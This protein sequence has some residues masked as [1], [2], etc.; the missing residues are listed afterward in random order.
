METK[1]ELLSSKSNYFYSPSKQNNITFRT[2]KLFHFHPHLSNSNSMS[3]IR[4][5]ITLKLKTAKSL[6]PR[7]K[8]EEKAIK[9]N[10]NFL[11]QDLMT[12]RSEIH[13]RKNDLHLLKIKFNKLLLDNIYNKTL[14]A[15]ILDI[16]MNK[17]ISK[18]MVFTKIRNCRLN[19]EKKQALLE[20]HE[21]LTLKLDIENKKNLLE[22]K[23]LYINDLEKNSKKKIVNNLENEYFI[24]CEKQRTLLKKLEKLEKKYN[25]YERKINEENEKI[26]K[27]NMS[28][29]K[30]IDIE[31]DKI[32]AVQKIFE[33]K[34]VIIRQMNQLVDKIKKL[35]K[36]NNDKEKQIKDQEKEI[37]LKV[38]KYRIISAYKKILPEEQTKI[39]SKTKSKEEIES[40]LKEYEKESKT[41]LE[42]YDTLNKKMYK[43]RDEKPKL[44]RKAV[45]PRKEIERMES[46]KKELEELKTTKEKT[47]KN[48]T[49]KQKDLKDINVQDIKDN[50]QYT[51]IIEKNNNCKDELNKKID[52]LRSKLIELNTKSNNLF[53]K[54]NKEKSEFDK[55]NQNLEET[56]KQFEQNDLEYKE[57]KEKQDE[58]KN[59]EQNKKERGRKRDIDRLKKDINRYSNENRKIS[60][61]N[62]TLQNELDNFNKGLEDFEQIKKDLSDAVAKLNSLKK[63]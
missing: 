52:E 53:N 26:K 56:K 47:E 9:Y 63:N 54:L 11:K 42:E 34:C 1:K 29:D 41:L 37:G 48:H 22:E 14:L 19:P 59:K 35:E 28:N 30:L 49:Q 2:A 7:L 16:P 32:D 33:E 24:K 36:T 51:E 39:N 10:T 21:V 43:Y 8:K 3:D 15:K 23:V 45:E 38:Q 4:Q 40:I 31:V 25:L 44:L 5:G 55:L 58:E 46:L 62:Q 12:L 50:E 17:I 13:Q 6:F 20:A 60:E 18:Q 27:E 61:Q 57:N